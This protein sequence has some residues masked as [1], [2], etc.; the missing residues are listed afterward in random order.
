MNESVKCKVIHEITYD[1][2]NKYFL[3]VSVTQRGEKERQ[4]LRR[5]MHAKTII[6]R[7]LIHKIK[8]TFGNFH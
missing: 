4:L 1:E 2:I 3:Q 8:A 5:N 6:T 7:Y